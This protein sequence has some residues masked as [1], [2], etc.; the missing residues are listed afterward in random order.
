MNRRRLFFF[1]LIGIKH[2]LHAL[3]CAKTNNDKRAKGLCD[4][5][6]VY[7]TVRRNLQWYEARETQLLH[8]VMCF[9]RAKGA[10]L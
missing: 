8:T 4:M 2:L 9:K 6:K 10:S 3:S 7:T 1:F 5:N